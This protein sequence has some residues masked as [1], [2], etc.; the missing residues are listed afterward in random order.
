M[1]HVFLYEFVTGGGWWSVDPDKPPSGSLLNEALAMVRALA[2]DCSRLPEIHLSRLWDARLPAIPL[3]GNCIAVHSAEQEQSRFAELAN[4]ADYALIIAPELDGYLLSR[5][6]WAEECQCELLSPNAAFVEIASNKQLTADLFGRSDVAAPRGILLSASANLPPW[7]QFPAVLKPNDGAGST[8]VALVKSANDLQRIDP[9]KHNLRLEQFCPGMAAS[10]AVLGGPQGN[11]L[12]PAG[13]QI[14][15]QQGD[16][17]Y[18]GGEMPL[19]EDFQRRARKLAQRAMGVLPKATGYV[20]ID[21]VLGEA[22]D[23]SQDVVI[24]V[25]PRLT[26]SYVGLRRI[27][28]QNLAS[29]ML[30]IARGQTVELGFANELVR[31]EVSGIG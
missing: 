1:N 2:E 21:L 19:P 4:Q 25:N 28:R 30:A 23:G 6:R 27:C 8:D 3:A 16:F 29:A 14:L 31:F 24:E 12:L 26:T 18:L 10:I 15:S 11:S 9:C 7:L 5:V 22:I 20:G 17:K 13:R